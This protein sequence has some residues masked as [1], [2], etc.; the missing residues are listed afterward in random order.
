[1][2][3]NR[4]RIDI[5]APGSA[6]ATRDASRAAY[7]AARAAIANPD[8]FVR[9]GSY[10]PH[11]VRGFILSHQFGLICIAYGSCLQDA[12]D[13][14][15]DAD[16]LDCLLITDPDDVNDETAYLGNASEPFDITYLHVAETDTRKTTP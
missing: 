16:R 13:A 6:L 9:P 8:D 4:Y 1:M 7:R 15:V 14:A 10:N 5:D 11:R 12:L 2:K 3:I